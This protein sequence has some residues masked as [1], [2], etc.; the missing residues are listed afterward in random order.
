MTAAALNVEQL[1]AISGDLGSINAGSL[2]I[3]NRFIVNETG[4]ATIK[5]ADSGARLV[6]SNNRI[7]VYDEAGQLRIRMG[8]L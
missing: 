2:N 1:S 3:N 5:S 4:D 8:E 7:D 6:I